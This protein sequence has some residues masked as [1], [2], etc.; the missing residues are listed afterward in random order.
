MLLVWS[1]SG[2][3]DE[4]IWPQVS[5]SYKKR[6]ICFNFKCFLIMDFMYLSAILSKPWWVTETDKT[7]VILSDLSILFLWTSKANALSRFS[8]PYIISF[9]SF[10]ASNGIGWSYQKLWLR[11]LYSCASSLISLGIFGEEKSDG[12][13]IRTLLE[14]KISFD[15]FVNKLLLSLILFNF[16]FSNNFL[17]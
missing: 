1:L 5:S 9:S 15:G 4:V 3:I 14:N 6:S 16:L 11:F 10:D 7:R 2:N 13:V 17:N 12:V 8:N